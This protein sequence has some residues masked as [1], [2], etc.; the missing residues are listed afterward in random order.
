[1]KTMGEKEIA[2]MAIYFF[3]E[4]SFLFHVRSAFNLHKVLLLSKQQN[5]Q[6]ALNFFIMSDFISNYV[7]FFYK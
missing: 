2:K 1:M 5:F 4:F 6:R 3:N 7:F